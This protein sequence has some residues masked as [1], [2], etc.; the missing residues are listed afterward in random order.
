ME[1]FFKS[2]SSHPTPFQG[3]KSYTRIK[4]SFTDDQKSNSQKIGIV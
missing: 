4:Q 1:S 3:W 2:A